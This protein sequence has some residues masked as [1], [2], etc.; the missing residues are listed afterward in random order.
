MLLDKYIV[1]KKRFPLSFQSADNLNPAVLALPLILMFWS[2]ATIFYYSE[3]GDMVMNKFH[4]FSDHS[5]RCRWYRF[6]RTIQKMFLIYLVDAQ[7]ECNIRGYGNTICTR[8]AFKEVH[9]NFI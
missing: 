7:R 5:L 2:I 3:F 6:P 8:N 4:I 9:F 1:K